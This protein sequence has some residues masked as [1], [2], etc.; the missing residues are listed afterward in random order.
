MVLFKIQVFVIQCVFS[1]TPPCHQE[2]EPLPPSHPGPLHWLWEAGL[3]S[4]PDRTT[5]L[6]P[7]GSPIHWLKWIS[8]DTAAS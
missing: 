6:L 8:D 4:T 7:L 1:L 3:P 5:L 2:V